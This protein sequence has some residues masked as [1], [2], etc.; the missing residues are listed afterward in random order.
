M[1]IAGVGWLA[2]GMIVYV[3]YRH[4]QGL[5]L[6]TTTKV[7]IPRPAT[8]TEAEYDAVLVAFDEQRLRAPR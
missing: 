7:A 6:V 5:D 1:A 4:R 2:V 3:V 8:E